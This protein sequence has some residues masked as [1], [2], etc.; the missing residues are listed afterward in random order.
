MKEFKYYQYVMFLPAFPKPNTTIK[1]T[2]DNPIT[3]DIV[4]RLLT[5]KYKYDGWEDRFELIDKPTVEII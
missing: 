1:I 2:S 4:E 5:Q 3:E